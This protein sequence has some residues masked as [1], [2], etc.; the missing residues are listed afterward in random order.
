MTSFA[1][2]QFV[3]WLSILGVAYIFVGYPL[4]MFA[5]ARWR[6][7]R[8]SKQR[9]ESPVSVV[10]VAYN[11][12]AR[13]PKKIASVLASDDT[14]L[15][16]EVLVASDGSTDNTGD[17]VA[18]LND[19]RVRV[20]SFTERRGKPSVL[21][22][23]VPN[24][25]SEIV[26][27]TDARQEL[28]RHAIAE[29]AANFADATVGAVSGELIFKSEGDTT[30]A[31]RGI[32]LYWRY[33]K[34]LRQHEGRFRSV[35]G[36]TGALYA[37]RRSLFRPI[38]ASTILDDVVI[39][40]QVVSAGYRCL[41]DSAAVAY[42]LPSASTSQ[43]SVRKRRTIAG[44]AQLVIN[45]PTC[46][47]PWRNP[48]WFEFVSHK[49]ARLVAPLLL[50]VA[51]V[52]NVALARQPIYGVLL[53]MHI[54]F[55]LSALAGWAFQRAGRRSSLFGAPLMFVTLNATTVAA[56]WD[57]LRGRFRATWQRAA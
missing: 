52:A 8:T 17:V 29:L 43:E 22:D 5:L 48:I 14:H 49:L 30:T 46:L 13:L 38:P 23:V 55:Y 31:S 25:R 19:P 35:P 37:I 16:H 44:A 39:P 10:I 12:A 50:L 4:V 24:C 15:I 7:L 47:L 20:V 45:Q 27:L 57:A 34:F 28:D 51:A 18:A 32:G 40:M 21:N 2:W 36:A 33:E 42:D 53:S 26:V 56:L 11:E 1:V 3:F 6:P 41:F 54:A 9:N